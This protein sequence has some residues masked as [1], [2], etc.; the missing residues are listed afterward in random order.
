[1]PETRE[2]PEKRVLHPWVQSELKREAEERIK[3]K[4]LPEKD[5]NEIRMFGSLVE[6]EF[7]RYEE[8]HEGQHYSDIDVILNVEESFEVPEEW[9]LEYR[10]EGRPY[11]VYVSEINGF[12]TEFYIYRSS[13]ASREEIAEAE[14]REVPLR[15][16]SQHEYQV[17][18]PEK[19][20]R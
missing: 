11:Q 17:I 2:K 3:K 13:Q 14:K 5:L 1:M 8:P 20:A 7:G 10:C 9:E 6:G 19:G 15:D 18:Y 16:E 12:K 4:L